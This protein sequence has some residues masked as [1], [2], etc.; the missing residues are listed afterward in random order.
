[1]KFKF[2][3]FAL[4]VSTPLQYSIAEDSSIK[5]VVVTG[6][7][8]VS[9][10]ATIAQISLAIQVEDQTASG[11]SKKAA[12]ISSE[13]ISWIKTQ[14]I[15]KLKTTGINLNPQYRYDSSKPTIIGYSASN[16]V[17][18]ETAVD[19]AGAILDEAVSKGASRIDA[20]QFTAPDD[21]LEAAK[22]SAIEKATLSAKTQG[23]KAL[24]ALGLV[25]KGISS[26]SVNSSSMMPPMP[27]PV[28]GRVAMMEAQSAPS[29]PVEGGELSVSASV[30]V[31]MSF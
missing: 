1:M 19:A 24:A 16:Q 20:V 7:E 8:E 11:A 26:I 12:K 14:K 25:S 13:V 9:V 30:T 22:L 18:F 27:R 15:S 17:F 31:G 2:L 5:Q 29:T 28:M 3:T 23:E 21:V 4:I 6:D 10:E